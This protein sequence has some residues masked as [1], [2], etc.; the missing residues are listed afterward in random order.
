MAGFGCAFELSA[1]GSRVGLWA[2]AMLTRRDLFKRFGWAAAVA[3]LA[4]VLPNIAA[5]GVPLPLRKTWYLTDADM[6]QWPWEP[7]ISSAGQ[8]YEAAPYKRSVDWRE[9][10]YD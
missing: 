5:A 4:L 1:A 3:P 10:G 9:I 8:R 6:W 2:R 7:H